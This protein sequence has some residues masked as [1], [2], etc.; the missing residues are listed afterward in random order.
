MCIRDRATTAAGQASA[1]TMKQSSMMGALFNPALVTFQ[2]Q[3]EKR[4]KNLMKR[5]PDGSTEFQQITI[6][7]RLGPMKDGKPTVLEE[8]TEEEFRQQCDV[9]IQQNKAGGAAPLQQMTTNVSAAKNP[10]LSH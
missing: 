6:R 4:T 8:M 10:F 9:V 5:K 2:K 1:N 3:F 7:V